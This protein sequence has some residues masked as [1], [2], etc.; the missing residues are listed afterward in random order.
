M[1][2][3]RASVKMVVSAIMQRANGIGTS[4][5]EAK[6]NSDITAI[7]GHFIS[8]KA[9]S[10]KSMDNLRSVVNQ[11]LD[12]T[13]ENN[14]GRVVGNIN[15]ET[16]KDFIEHKLD[17]GLS[18]ASANTYLSELSKMSDNLNSLGV[19]TTSRE[20]ISLDIRNDLKDQGHDLGALN[21]DR[22]NING[23]AMVNFMK[24][25]S[26]YGL[27]AELQKTAGLRVDDA[28][29]IGQKITINENGSLHIEGSKNGNDYDTIPLNEDLL[30]R[31]QEAINQNYSVNY[32]EYRETLKESAE[33]TGNEWNGTHSL[34]FDYANDQREEGKSL[35]QISIS[36]GHERP[37]I[38]ER[39]LT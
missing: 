13:K 28:L 19:E 35:E 2:S 23:E 7:N 6:A 5:A 8:D 12:H 27:E 15:N 20:V 37:E 17:N 14:P 29:N 25:N 10:L 26:P 21:K 1:I 31:V 18:G 4:K 33:A 36:M 9:H 39:Y 34:R 32:S 38:T 11:Y 24:E 3:N 16:I 22:T 30:N